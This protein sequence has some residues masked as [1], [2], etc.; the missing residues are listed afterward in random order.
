MMAE[1]AK[2]TERP[3]PLAA[4]GLQPKPAARIEQKEVESE[5]AAE[6]PESARIEETRQRRK[7]EEELA[8]EK[9]TAY[10]TPPQYDKIEELRRAHRKR[11][12]KRLSVNGRARDD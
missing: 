11:T 9:V 3:N 5:R 12:G 10:F 6:M 4:V 7:S 2:S 1:K 8:T